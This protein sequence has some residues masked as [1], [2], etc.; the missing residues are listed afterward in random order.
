MIGDTPPRKFGRAGRSL[1]DAITTEYQVDDA[2]GRALLEQC[3]LANDRLEALAARVDEDGET[4]RTRTGITKVHPGLPE[5]L[6][7]RSLICKTLER[8]GVNLEVIKPVGRPPRGF[9]WTGE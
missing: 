1:W 8:L 3:C 6:A 9:G 4:I 2:G 5:E 7:L